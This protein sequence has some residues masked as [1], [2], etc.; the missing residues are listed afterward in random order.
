MRAKEG[1]KGWRERGE[2]NCGGTRGRLRKQAKRRSQVVEECK[3]EEEERRRRRVTLTAFH[4]QFSP[5]HCP[6]FG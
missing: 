4:P 2:D 1:R 6:P 5:S 3:P